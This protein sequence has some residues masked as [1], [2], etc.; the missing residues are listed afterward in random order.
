[1]ATA[2]G[3]F[4]MQGQKEQTQKAQKTEN[5]KIF[6]WKTPTQGK[7]DGEEEGMFSY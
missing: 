7:T 3:S 2:D 6:T 5:T 1:M 4:L